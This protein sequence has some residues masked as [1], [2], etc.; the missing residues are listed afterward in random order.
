MIV[1]QDE[2]H[3]TPVIDPQ[4][5]EDPQTIN[6]I[7][8]DLKKYIGSALPEIQ[9][10]EVENKFKSFMQRFEQNEEQY[11]VLRNDVNDLSRE[12]H[13]LKSVVQDLNIEVASLKEK[14]KKTIN[15]QNVEKNQSEDMEIDSSQQSN[16]GQLQVLAQNKNSGYHR[17]SPQ[18]SP[19]KKT[20]PQKIPITKFVPQS[21]SKVVSGE[22]IYC[23]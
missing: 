8:V 3:F 19:V 5:Q 12:N 20:L 7:I 2:V 21:C 15:V 11:K 16:I 6:R 23:L 13:E 4:S 17:A 22:A 18:S 10:S 14:I 9:V 1:N